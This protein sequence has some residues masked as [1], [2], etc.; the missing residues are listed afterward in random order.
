MGEKEETMI[1]GKGY[2]ARQHRRMRNAERKR[3][4]EKKSLKTSRIAREETK[5]K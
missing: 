5:K 1:K 3:A 2:K 4:E